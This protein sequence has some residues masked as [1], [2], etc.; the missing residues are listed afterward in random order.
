M[1]LMLA[2]FFMGA[3]AGAD[4]RRTPNS[5]TPP[6]A[7]EREGQVRALWPLLPQCEH[8]RVIPAGARGALARASGVSFV[9]TR[10]Q[11]RACQIRCRVRW[12]FGFFA[13][14]S[15]L[16]EKVICREQSSF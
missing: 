10:D 9:R 6:P 5:L 8:R 12:F 2:L 14:L 15:L 13:L 1:Q 7:P 3:S 4:V 16:P 11:R